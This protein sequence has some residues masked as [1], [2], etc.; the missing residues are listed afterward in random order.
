MVSRLRQPSRRPC[1]PLHPWVERRHGQGT[2][3]TRITAACARHCAVTGE[4][5]LAITEAA[6]LKPNATSGPNRTFFEHHHRAIFRLCEQAAH[7]AQ[8][9]QLS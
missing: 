1:D 4:R 3:R 2:F 5:T 8:I 6:R 9:D 7:G